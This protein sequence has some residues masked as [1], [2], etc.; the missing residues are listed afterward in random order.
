MLRDSSNAGV[1]LA[2]PA[3]MD[4]GTVLTMNAVKSQRI[5]FSTVGAGFVV[6]P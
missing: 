6:H 2:I 3:E 5:E 1:S 4:K